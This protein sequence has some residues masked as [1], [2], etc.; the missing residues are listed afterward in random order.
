MRDVKGAVC[1]GWQRRVR[2]CKLRRGLL[3][4]LRFRFNPLA[5]VFLAKERTTE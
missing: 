2:E 5:F 1:F 3:G 4:Y